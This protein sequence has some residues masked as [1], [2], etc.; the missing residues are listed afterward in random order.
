[1]RLLIALLLAVMMLVPAG[2]APLEQTRL[3]LEGLSCE[4]LVDPLGIDVAKPRLS[5]LLTPGPRGRRQSAYQILVASSLENLRKD[6]GDLWNPGKVPSGQSTFVTYDGRPLQSGTRCFWKVRVWDEGDRPS[7]WSRTATWS[8]GVLQES[9]WYGRWIG[10]S[11]PAGVKE[12]T[13][14]PFPWLRKTFELRQKPRQATAYVNAQGYYELY[15]NGRKVDDHVLAP[16]VSD[17]SKRNLYVTHDVTIK[18][19]INK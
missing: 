6:R 9:E 17:F 2:S 18:P 19:L 15:I 7:P 1:M 5:W 13:P 3:A 14:L 4:Y 10:L 8:M 12:G 11:R 16:A